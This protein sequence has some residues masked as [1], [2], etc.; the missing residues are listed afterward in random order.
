MGVPKKNN[1]SKNYFFKKKKNKCLNFF[2]KT[3]ENL[4]ITEKINIMEYTE[5]PEKFISEADILVRPSLSGDPWG[6]D[7]IEAMS[8]ST[9]IIATGK[10]IYL[11]K[12]RFLGQYPFLIAEAI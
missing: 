12:N 3:L 9:A 1:I 7:I 10:W 8:S 6:R 2:Y 5:F 11:L 4:D